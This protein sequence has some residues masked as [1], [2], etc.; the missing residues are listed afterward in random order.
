MAEL[1]LHAQVFGETI[2]RRRFVRFSDRALDASEAFREIAGLL[3]AATVENFAT[4]G[5]SGGSRWRDLAPATRARKARLHLDQRILFA[6]HRL[7]NSLVGTGDPGGSEHVQEIGPQELRWGSSVGYGIFHQ[8][9]Q[10]RRVI[11]YR[12]PVR[13]TQVLRRDIVKVLQRALVEEG[14]V[15]PRPFKVA[16]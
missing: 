1:E 2:V 4:R 14:E 12:P 10:P 9:S 15:L 16:S 7:Y 8:S 5:V 11:P 6:T 3:R 13:L